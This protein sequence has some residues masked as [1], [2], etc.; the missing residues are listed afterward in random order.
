MAAC[1]SDYIVSDDSSQESAELTENAAKNTTDEMSQQ[2]D[3]EVETEETEILQFV[4]VYGQQYETEI[5][6]AVEKH[7]YIWS[8]L[9][10]D[11]EIASYEDTTYTSRL[12]IDVSYH[13]GE[14]DW[15]KVKDYGV[16]F[17]YIRIGY[18]GY[19]ESGVLCEDTKA[20][21]YISEAQ[22]AGIDVGVY[23]FSQAISEEEALEE[24]EFVIEKLQGIELQLPVVYDPESILDDEARTDDVSGEQFTKNTITFCR[25]IW[26]AGYE[27][28]IYSNML[29][30][31]FEFDLEELTN[32]EI[33]YADYEKIPQTPYHFTFWQ[34]TNSGSVN[35]IDGAVDLDIQIYEK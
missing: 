4:D 17:A 14:I 34:Y 26:E 31:A 19:G 18:R 8:N 30:E 20:L 2:S 21:E 22:K 24:A 35:G 6:S 16:T 15:Q 13:Q 3:E 5:L 28:M 9:S 11:G 23:F 27:P 33:W 12:G 1:A 10:W 25:R 7:A 32:L 29:W